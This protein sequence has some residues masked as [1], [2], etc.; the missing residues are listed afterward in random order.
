MHPVE[1]LGEY[2]VCDLG[3]LVGFGDVCGYAKYKCGGIGSVGHGVPM[4]ICGVVEN[5]RCA[6]LWGMGDDFGLWG[7][8]EAVG[9]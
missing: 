8:C 1:P 5:V 2:M 6:W 7:V 3:F 4:G 9:V